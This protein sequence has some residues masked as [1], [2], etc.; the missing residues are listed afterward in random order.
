MP[1]VTN[2]LHVY[3]RAEG[4]SVGEGDED[5]RLMSGSGGEEWG[6][7]AK[8]RQQTTFSQ[9]EQSYEA[10]FNK[11]RPWLDWVVSVMLL[12]YFQDRPTRST[13]LSG[14]TKHAVSRGL[15]L[16][17]VERLRIAQEQNARRKHRGIKRHGMF[18]HKKVRI[19]CCA[20]KTDLGFRKINNTWI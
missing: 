8:D 11:V 12:E 9:P 5:N 17:Y 13:K 20:Q 15:Q 7:G 18:K 10:A 4:E 2:M 14:D 16:P 3:T 1:G 6:A 19:S